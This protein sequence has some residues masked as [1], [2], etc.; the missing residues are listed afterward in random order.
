MSASGG[1]SAL[2]FSAVVGLE[3]AKLALLLAAS[4]PRLGGV[5]LRGEKGSAKTTLTPVADRFH[6]R[7]SAGAGSDGWRRQVVPN[8]GW[9]RGARR[10]SAGAGDRASVMG[11]PGE[12]RY[13]GGI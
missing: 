6:T 1:S 8:A 2:P 10:R 7:P 9:N 11:R 5:L 12:E 13:S 4:E 3:D